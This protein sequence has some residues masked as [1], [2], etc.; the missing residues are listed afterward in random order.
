MHIVTKATRARGVAARWKK[1]YY[2]GGEWHTINIGPTKEIYD[3]LVAAGENITPEEAA[4][5]IGNES[6]TRN[7]CAECG[8]DVETTVHFGEKEDYDVAWANVCPDCLREA[9]ALYDNAGG[10]LADSDLHEDYNRKEGKG[11]E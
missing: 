10:M 9:L 2:Y 5:I 11:G 8:Y 3:Q 4:T 6:W 7:R 1:A